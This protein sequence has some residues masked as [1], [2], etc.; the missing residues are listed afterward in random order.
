MIKKLFSLAALV[1][2]AAACTD[3]IDSAFDGLRRLAQTDQ[4][5]TVFYATIEGSAD[6]T[7]TKVFA[8]DQLRVLWN[9][10]D[11]I[12]IFNKNTGNLLYVFA[13]EEGDNAGEFSYVSGS[14][15]SKAVSH[16]YAV[17]PYSESTTISNKG[18][19]SLALP[20]IQT[21][22]ENSFGIGANTMVSV[23]DDN[24]LMFRN[25]GGYL[26]FK[27][28]G[29]GV[30]V[31]SITLK[32]NNHEK[33]A[34]A[35]NVTMP[36]NGTPTT[37]MQ[38]DATESI[39]LTCETPVALGADADHYTEFWFVIPPTTF[40]NGFT[41]R[42][43][44]NQGRVFEK[45]TSSSSI[46]IARNNL[47]RM[48]PMEV[49]P[50]NIAT[51]LYQF[52]PDDIGKE[53]IT[54]IEFHVKDA[55]V[56]DHQLSASVPVYYEKNGSTVKLYTSAELYDISSRECMFVGYSALRTIDLSNTITPNCTSLRQ[57]FCGCKDL[58]SINFGDWNTSLVTS[59]EAMFFGC[60]QL[61][62]L[63]LSFMNTSNVESMRQMFTSCKSLAALD[64]SPFNTSK[65]TDMKD[66]FR[67]CCALHT[68]D[69]SSFDTRKITDMSNMF[70]SCACLKTLN[71]SSFDTQNVTDMS[72]MFNDCGS[73]KTIDLSSFNTSNVESF[74]EMFYG[75]ENLEYLDLTH[76]RTSNVKNMLFMFGWCTSLNNPNIS[77]FTSESLQTAKLMFGSCQKLQKL[78]LGAFDISVANC[79]DI[80]QA[81]M[82][83][84]KSGAIRC[85]PET[86]AILEPT[87]DDNLFGKVEWLSL[88]DDIST[89]EYHEQR[90]PNLYYSS[91]FSKHET[92]RK[93]YSATKG[94]G[95]DIVLM[96]DVYS[97]RMIASGLYD[98]DMEL[99]ADAIFAKEPMASF[100]DYFNVYIVYLVS[101][102]EV[103][104]ESTALGAV[105]SG[106]GIDGYASASVPAKYRILA[107]GNGDLKVQEAIVIINGT[108]HVSG[109]TNM[110]YWSS[111]A[112]DYGQ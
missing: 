46:T 90:D 52:L 40:T 47:S 77:S 104:E 7:S 68:L 74:R 30:S 21:Y 18:V 49:I 110:T 111:D 86:K 106:A 100:K 99:A 88:S 60:E 79:Q 85:I 19:L 57:M 9:K 109:Y 8:D 59:M 91:D 103:I 16:I 97:D 37:I 95:I 41:V 69:V 39:T 98:A 44:D 83:S 24:K 101:D 13:G 28:Y 96:G 63:D 62:S 20:A 35:A 15:T 32:G 23:T 94:R 58:M 87:M 93:L 76:F 12:S 26:S 27:L 71:L 25:V 43:T 42:I 29:E 82:K 55:T 102:N 65:V 53:T 14:A 61:R 6:S 2:M 66:L 10:N 64:L 78:N 81:I 4:D 73:L 89:Y 107:T 1:L 54:G 80:G 11:N 92:V 108:D 72:W 17:Y 48:S 112:G 45:S 22:K 31:K 3:I 67:N 34:G 70:E 105:A 51:T 38:D 5:G 56:T 75:C 36:V 33:L 50:V 84:S